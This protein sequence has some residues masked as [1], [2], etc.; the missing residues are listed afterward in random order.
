MDCTQ[1]ALIMEECKDGYHQNVV[2]DHLSM[3]PYAVKSQCLIEFISLD[4]ELSST[5]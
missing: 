1:P 2:V 5:L 4:Q 3:V